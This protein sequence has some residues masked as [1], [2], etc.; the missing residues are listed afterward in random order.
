MALLLPVG[1]FQETLHSGMCGPAALCMVLSY[2][3]VGRTEAEL[4][5]M[6]GTDPMIGTCDSALKAVAE[7]LGFVVEIKTD[8]TINDIQEWLIKKVP[9]IV[10]WF[11]RGRVDYD[12]SEVPDGH[13]S[14]VVGMDDESIYLQDPEIGALRRLGRSDFIRVWFDF[15]GQY[16]T[17]WNDLIIRQLIAI[18]PRD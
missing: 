16:I 10:N 7:T 13:F 8:G 14:V 9:V 3:G 6:C 2:Y 5:R 18:Y 11:S 1:P 4:A 15:R 12:S 17:G